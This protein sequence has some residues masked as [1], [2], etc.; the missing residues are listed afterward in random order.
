MIPEQHLPCHLN[1]SHS[2][3]DK[4]NVTWTNTIA[5]NDTNAFHLT[6]THT[7]QIVK[8]LNCLPSLQSCEKISLSQH[9][10]LLLLLISWFTL[11]SALC[12]TCALNSFQQP[13]Y[14]KQQDQTATVDQEWTTCDDHQYFQYHPACWIPQ[15]Y[16][17]KAKLR[18]SEEASSSLFSAC[19]LI[20]LHIWLTRMTCGGCQARCKWCTWVQKSQYRLQIDWCRNGK[21]MQPLSN[22]RAS[23]VTYS[24]NMYRKSWSNCKT[25]F[26][27][28]TWNNYIL[29]Y[30]LGFVVHRI[31]QLN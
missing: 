30:Y 8:Q 22:Q 23:P 3:G 12:T 24:V 9:S 1:W 25:Q 10:Q 20:L 17:T 18:D 29:I 11:I 27:Q 2:L 4:H 13:C 5:N 28:D 31:A 14:C 26:S 6:G 15:S 7:S 16:C 21:D 19:W